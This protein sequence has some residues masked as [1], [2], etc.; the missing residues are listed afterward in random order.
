M[1]LKNICGKGKL[2]K[3]PSFKSGTVSC[4]VGCLSCVIATAYLVAADA[5]WWLLGIV[6]AG[7][8]IG[9][10]A[11]LFLVHDGHRNCWLSSLLFSPYTL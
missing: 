5:S 8:V 1:L 4:I 7:A 11:V 2:L 9:F 3:K 6:G 10:L